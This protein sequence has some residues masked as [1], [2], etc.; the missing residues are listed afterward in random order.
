MNMT[1]TKVQ[2]SSQT[3]TPFAGISF[4]NEEFFHCG[5]ARLIDKELGYRQSTKGFKHG[6]AHVKTYQAELL[7]RCYKLLNDNGFFINRSRMDAG[8][9]SKEIIELVSKNSKL[10]YIR[11]NRSANM[12]EQISQITDWQTSVAKTFTLNKISF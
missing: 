3:I 6:N 11:A 8:S 12:T 7:E 9:Y 4:I 10:F 2:K 1:G 5:L